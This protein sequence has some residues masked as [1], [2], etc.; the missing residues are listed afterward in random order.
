MDTIKKLIK[1]NS[2]QL[3]DKII[4]LIEKSR[5]MRSKVIAKPL[6]NEDKIKLLVDDTFI[7]HIV[8]ML[9][10]IQMLKT[11]GN[12]YD[13][14]LEE[15]I[16][17][18]IEFNTDIKLLNSIIILYKNVTNDD[19]KFF[20]LKLIKSMEKYGT[21]NNDHDKILDIFKYNEEKVDEF[22]RNNWTLLD[23]QRAGNGKLKFK[24]NKDKYIININDDKYTILKNK[25]YMTSNDVKLLIKDIKETFK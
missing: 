17:Y 2:N 19:D 4:F 18:N 22:I 10:Q 8:T 12:E 5:E 14:L 1:L 9:V 3:K 7:F 23:I 20:L 21:C 25:K 6:N 16:N 13:L 24:I 11:N 15:L